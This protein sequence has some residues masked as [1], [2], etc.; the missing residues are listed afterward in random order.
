VLARKMR[1]DLPSR[2]AKGG[3]IPGVRTPITINGARMFADRAPPVHGEH[4]DEVL[5]EIGE[6]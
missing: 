4:T 1:I 5:R 2:H 6:A 3:Y